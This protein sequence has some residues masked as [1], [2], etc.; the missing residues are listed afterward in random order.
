MLFFHLGC[1]GMTGFFSF[2]PTLKAA[3]LRNSRRNSWQM[4]SPK[5]LPPP[6][7]CP[8]G[9]RTMTTSPSRCGLPPQD[10][11]PFRAAQTLRAAKATKKAWHGPKENHLKLLELMME[12][13][14]TK[15][16]IGRSFD[17][18]WL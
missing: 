16:A 6:A 3:P 17:A 12:K 5:N 1:G 7:Q 8:S 14:I 2:Q 18:S 13:A 4:V 10:L 15:T 9:A 11:R